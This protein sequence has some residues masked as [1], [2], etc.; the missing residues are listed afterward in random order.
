M[1]KSQQP[2]E[3][4]VSAQPHILHRSRSYALLVE[5]WEQAR[6]SKRK[7]WGD[8][9]PCQPYEAFACG[10]PCRA[11]GRALLGAPTPGS[12]VATDIAID[13]DNAAF[14]SEHEACRMG[15]WSIQDRKVDHC[16]LCCPFPPIGPSQR[17]ELRKI[18]SRPVLRIYRWRVELTCG[19]IETTRS[20]IT[21]QAQATTW[22]PTCAVARGVIT[23]ARVDNQAVG[24][25]DV[26]DASV[27]PLYEPLTDEQWNR[28]K[29]IAQTEGLPHR[30]RPRA[31]A[32]TIVEAIL[33]RAHTGITW[34]DLPPKF[35]PWQTVSRRYRQLVA[36]SQWDEITRALAERASPR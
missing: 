21:D 23:A 20:G 2:P 14:H 5:S 24:N 18:L 7:E 3:D 15:Y 31:D 33:Y 25:A 30:G 13:S 35:G 19:H 8:N 27:V 36:S 10:E 29:H 6:A 9:A 17:E 4:R 26:T 16:H 22:C 12:K 1:P 34:R 11:C 28:I 32:R